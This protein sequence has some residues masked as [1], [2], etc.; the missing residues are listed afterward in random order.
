ME[1]DSAV[2]VGRIE[3]FLRALNIDLLKIVER[4]RELEELLQSRE[5]QHQN[6][7][8]YWYTGWFT[9]HA[10]PNLAFNNKCIQVLI[11]GIY[12]YT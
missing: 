8:Y 6:N 10:R 7:V 1:P 11:F 4:D 12:K 2:S 5:M 9:K 3:A